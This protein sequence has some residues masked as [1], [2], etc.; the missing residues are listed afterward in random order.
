VSQCRMVDVAQLAALLNL[1]PNRVG[2]RRRVGRT[3]H[4]RPVCQIFGDDR[5][6][7]RTRPRIPPILIVLHGELSAFRL[8]RVHFEHEP[9]L[10]QVVLARRTPRGLPSPSQRRQQY[11]GQNA[12]DGNHH[13]QLNQC[14]PTLLRLHVLF[15]PLARYRPS[16][17][18]L[19]EEILSQCTRSQTALHSA[20]VR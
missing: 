12:D 17:S 13:Q 18:T 15:L 3:Q 8:P 9:H 16:A 10:F 6:A 20:I 2:I 1:G 11:R 4:H 19:S 7:Q 5:R 14:E